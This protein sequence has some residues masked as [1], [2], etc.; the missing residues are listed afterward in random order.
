M[1]FTILIISLPVYSHHS[2][3]WIQQVIFSRLL[4]IIAAGLHI[5]FLTDFF[6]KVQ[7]PNPDIY[8][9]SVCGEHEDKTVLHRTL[10]LYGQG[11]SGVFVVI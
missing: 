6:F 7:Y 3:L 2:F 9:K 4:N 8:S 5:H 10:S 1:Y 11:V